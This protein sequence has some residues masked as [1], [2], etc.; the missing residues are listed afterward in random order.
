MLSWVIVVPTSVPP[1][2]SIFPWAAQLPV[3]APVQ[4]GRGAPAPVQ[5]LLPS[6]R[7][8]THSAPPP[9]SLKWT[10]ESWES[11]SVATPSAPGVPAVRWS[12]PAKSLS[13]G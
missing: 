4:H 5:R 3:P 8:L 13:T 7:N 2:Q 10:V 12:V 9:M 11:V 1:S 6:T